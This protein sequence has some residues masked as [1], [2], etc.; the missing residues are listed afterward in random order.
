MLLLVYESETVEILLPN[1][2]GRCRAG[3]IKIT[4]AVQGGTNWSIA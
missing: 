1:A 3:G 2:P 4:I